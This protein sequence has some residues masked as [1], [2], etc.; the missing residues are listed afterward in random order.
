MN[1]IYPGGFVFS[2]H[3][4]RPESPLTRTTVESPVG[5]LS[6]FIFANYFQKKK[7]KAKARLSKTGRIF[8][9]A[10]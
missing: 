9:P 3:P 1:E 7:Q 2:L 8:L 5:H 4:A 6:I 10:Y